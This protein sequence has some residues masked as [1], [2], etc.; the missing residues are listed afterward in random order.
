MATTSSK[1]STHSLEHNIRKQPSCTI[2][3]LERPIEKKARAA[4]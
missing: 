4:G 3:W 1:P 2:Y